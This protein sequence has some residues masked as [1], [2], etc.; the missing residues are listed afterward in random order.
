MNFT[1]A[2]LKDREFS[3]K[4]EMFTAIKASKDDIISLKKSSI[5]HSLPVH[6]VHKNGDI[7]DK[8]ESLKKLEYGDYV[9]PVIN[10]T[11]YLDHHDDVHFPGI[12]DKSI[13]AQTGKVYLVINHDLSIGKVISYPR[14]VQP[15]VKMMNWSDLG[16]DY[17]G[18]TQALIFKSKMTEKTNKDAFLAYRDGEEIQHSIRMQYVRLELAINDSRPDFKAEKAVW[19]K[20]IDQ[21]A[22]K[23]KAEEQGFFWA[24]LEAKIFKEGSAVL[25]GSNDATPTLYDIDEKGTQP[26]T[27]TEGEPEPPTS[28]QSKSIFELINSNF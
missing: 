21:I 22:N 4:E 28:T 27:S 15:L 20:F 13:D 11:N 10:T 23:D 16:K 24:I 1:C 18:Q 8:K 5:K 26:P 12:W 2:T 6:Y 9:Y 7:Q 19:D 3:T 14:D 25:F 17:S